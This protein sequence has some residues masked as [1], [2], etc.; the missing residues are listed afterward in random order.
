MLTKAERTYSEKYLRKLRLM[1]PI[2]TRA[3]KP[4]SFDRFLIQAR[5]CAGHD[6][7]HERGKI[8]CPT[9]VI[10]GDSDKTVGPESSAELAKAISGSRL[11]VYKGLGHSAYEEA[12]DF[13]DRVLEFLKE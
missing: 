5:S 6:A 10:G 12:K 8:S 9:F 1:Y 4:K 2:L 11:Y 13:N 7:Y 3:G